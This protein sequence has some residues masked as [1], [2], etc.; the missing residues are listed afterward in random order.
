M[1]IYKMEVLV[2]EIS[3]DSLTE[4]SAK[5]I[6][7]NGREIA[8]IKSNHQ[9]FAVG[10]ECPHLGGPIGEGCVV[11]GKVTCPWHDWTFDL[12]SGECDINPAAKITIYP[13]SITDGGIIIEID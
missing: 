10:N 12:T 5:I 8:F 3:P 4:G 7:I 2:Q 1:G 11:D 9:I 6:R 13:V